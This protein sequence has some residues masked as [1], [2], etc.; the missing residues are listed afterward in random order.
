M[1]ERVAAVRNPWSTAEREQHRAC[2]PRDGVIEHRCVVSPR[3]PRREPSSFTP[4][5]SVMFEPF[6]FE[7]LA[8]LNRPDSDVLV[9]CP[10][11]AMANT[12]LEV[13]PPPRTWGVGESM[14]A[15]ADGNYE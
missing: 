1:P 8:R 10:E 6:V 15:S 5:A 12:K 7:S 3:T 11:P 14:V 2:L 4:P 13:A 9:R